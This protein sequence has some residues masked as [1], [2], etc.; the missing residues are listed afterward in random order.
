MGCCFG[1]LNNYEPAFAN[2]D[3][4]PLRG[5]PWTSAYSVDQS[6][7]DRLRDD[8]WFSTKGTEGREV[9]WETLKAA[10]ETDDDELCMAILD[11]AGIVP[12]RGCMSVCYDPKGARYELPNYVL[13]PPSN[14]SSE[15]VPP[16]T[17]SERAV[18]SLE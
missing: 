17:R 11:A 5:L 2:S 3:P 8:F 16:R 10:T 18:V 7:L 4:L 6:E 9:I 15:P 12:E 1:R 13:R 14:L